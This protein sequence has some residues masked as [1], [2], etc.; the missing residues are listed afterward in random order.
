MVK[1]VPI[2]IVRDAEGVVHLSLAPSAVPLAEITN[3]GTRWVWTTNTILKDDRSTYCGYIAKER[4]YGR[5]GGSS[6]TLRQAI[7]DVLNNRP[8][9]VVTSNWEQLCLTP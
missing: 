9:V 3:V 1:A 7:C 4:R 8:Y 5:Y 2:A 6:N